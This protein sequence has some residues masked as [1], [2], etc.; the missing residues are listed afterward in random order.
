VPFHT[1]IQVIPSGGL[2]YTEVGAD[3][4]IFLLELVIFVHT[5]RDKIP[6][7]DLPTVLQGLM[8]HPFEPLDDLSLK[9]LTCKTVFS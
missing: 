3:L 5:K 4:F 1:S 2:R 6:M 9:Y 7:W 8:A